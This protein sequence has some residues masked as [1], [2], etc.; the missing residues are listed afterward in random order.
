MVADYL[1]AEVLVG[2]PP[3]TR[4]F[5]RDISVC[6]ECPVELAIELMGRDDAQ[7]LLNQLEYQAALVSKDAEQDRYR[8]QPLVR[9]YLHADL[10]RADPGRWQL[11]HKRAALWWARRGAPTEALTHS[12][13]AAD[14]TLLIQLLRQFGLRLIVTG[15]HPHLRA[16]H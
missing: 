7:G 14:H 5:L 10:R 15:G 3:P 16:A 11:L 6:P 12:T 1:V 9:T 2:L 4:D 8:L 13:T